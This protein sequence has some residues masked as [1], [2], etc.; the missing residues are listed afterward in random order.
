MNEYVGHDSQLFGIEEHRLVGGKGDGMRLYEINNGR[1]LELTV[2]PDRNG[3]ITR[4]RFK[5][6]NLSYMSP[7]GYV[8]PAYYDSIGSNWLNSF[9]AGFLTTC[10]LNGVGTP[11]NDNGEEIPLHGSIA[12]TPCDQSYFFEE[13]ESD[14]VVLTVKTVTK[15]ETIFGRKLRLSRRIQV[16]TEENSFVITDTVENTGGKEEPFEI[17]YHMN[18]GY[19]LL[20]EDSIITIPS[21]EVIPRDDHA[22]EDI[23]NWRYMEKPSADYQERCYYHR[24]DKKDVSVSIGQPKLDVRLSLEFDSSSLDGFVEWKM[25]GVRDYVLGLECGNCY[26]D[27]RDVMRK[28]GMLKFL[29]P[30]Q[31]KT[32]SVKVGVGKNS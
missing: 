15:D 12:N 22:A 3:D 10:G 5:G 27:G 28:K 9:T 26:P 16:S 2:S 4:L 6:I 11:C 24:F 19:P 13:A 30:G 14:H 32:Y 23:A 18:M 17:L 25:M 20:D 29:E 21:T 1:G 8:A 31:K 7:C